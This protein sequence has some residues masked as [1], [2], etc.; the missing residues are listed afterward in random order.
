MRAAW[1]AVAM[2]LSSGSS[3]S[4]NLPNVVVVGDSIT[5]MAT[6]GLDQVLDPHFHIEVIAK[7][8]KRIDQMLPA[9]AAALQV[10]PYAVIE[11]LGTNDAREGG[12]QHDWTSS[13]NQLVA[14]T[15]GVPCVVLTTIGIANDIVYGHKSVAAVIN[16]DIWKLAAEDPK[17]YEVADWNGFLLKHKRSDW[18]KYLRGDLIHPT[19][20]GGIEIAKLDKTAL[21][22]CLALNR[23][24][25]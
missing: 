23:W 5:A 10:H 20:A 8:G 16:R 25:K 18:R 12:T 22:K 6:P 15:S 9:L 7:Y 13:W 1:I 19:P 2:L 17:H 14:M 21:A 4:A 24:G 3:S 11:D